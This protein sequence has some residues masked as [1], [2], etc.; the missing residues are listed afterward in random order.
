[1]LKKYKFLFS[2]FVIWWSSLVLILVV[3]N[4]IIP[5]RQSQE[6]TNILHTTSQSILDSSFFYPWANFDGVHYLAIAKYGYTTEAGFFPFYPLLIKI[7]S[8]INIDYFFSALFISNLA[9]IIGLIFLYKLIRLDFSDKIARQSLFFLLI[10]PTSF[11]FASIYSESL[12]FLLLILCF[13]FARKKMWL[14]AAIPGMFLSAT[15]IVGVLILPA[16]LWEFYILEKNNL[17]SNI[18]KIIPIIIIPLGLFS[19]MIFN[20]LNWG[21][22]FYFA[23]AQGMLS[24][25][26][27]VDQIILFPQTLFRYFKIIT[28]VPIQQFEWWI[29]VLEVGMSVFAVTL[30]Y[31]AYKQKIRISYLVFSVLALL[32][33]A[34]SGTLSGMPRYILVSFPIFIS[35]ALIKNRWIKTIYSIVS[36]I[37]LIILWILF[38]KGYYVA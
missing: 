30:L 15:R 31:I 4:K 1:M 11:F 32:L 21:N 10:F 5:Y 13:Y 18:Q 28:T 16:L 35:L 37:L 20:F 26:R 33:P 9:F 8:S 29:A 25:N 6:F 7:F 23:K 36:V 3:S 38:S 19:Y 14:F 17:R 22:L 27:S 12:F 24:N 2:F 34:S